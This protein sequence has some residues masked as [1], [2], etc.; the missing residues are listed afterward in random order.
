MTL[1]DVTPHNDVLTFCPVAPKATDA[2][3]CRLAGDLA[4]RGGLTGAVLYPNFFSYT[5]VPLIRAAESGLLFSSGSLLQF[6]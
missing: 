4:P 6:N 5:M 2:V 1:A 3:A